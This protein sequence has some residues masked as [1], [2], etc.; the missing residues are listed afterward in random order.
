MKRMGKKCAIQNIWEC[1]RE[2]SHQ[3]N[4]EKEKERE[5]ELPLQLQ[6]HAYSLTSVFWLA[7]RTTKTNYTRLNAMRVLFKLLKKISYQN[8]QTITNMNTYE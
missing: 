7:H 8:S 6:T 5:K 1:E 2:R 3:S 4:V